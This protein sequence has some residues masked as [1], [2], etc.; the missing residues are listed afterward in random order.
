M[1]EDKQRAYRQKVL[2]E[3]EQKNIERRL[4]L[5]EKAKANYKYVRLEHEQKVKEF[6]KLHPGKELV[7]RFMMIDGE[8]KKVEICQLVEENTII[9]AKL[10]N[11]KKWDRINDWREKLKK[12]GIKPKKKKYHKEPSDLSIHNKS[13]CK[14]PVW[15]K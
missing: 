5:K 15:R 8:Y 14:V 7:K 10:N 12:A 6:K 2:Q 9:I 1:V 11:K 13:L 3:I 4:K